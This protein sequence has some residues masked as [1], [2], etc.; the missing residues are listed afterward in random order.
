MVQGYNLFYL[1]KMTLIGIIMSAFIFI[2]HALPK[3]LIINEIIQ[4]DFASFQFFGG[5]VLLF[6]ARHHYIC[7]I[8]ERLIERYIEISEGITALVV[9]T[10]SIE[11]NMKGEISSIRPSQ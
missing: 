2:L 4:M 9:G 1:L 10:F 7:T 3:E 11:M 5:I 6:I 8:N